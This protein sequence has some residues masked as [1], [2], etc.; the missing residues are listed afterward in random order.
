MSTK[1]LFMN[2][3]SSSNYSIQ[4]IRGCKQTKTGIQILTNDNVSHFVCS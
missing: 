3:L 2:W 1:D 4:D